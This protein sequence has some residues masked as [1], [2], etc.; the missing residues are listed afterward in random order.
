[1]LSVP[2][3]QEHAVGEHAVGPADLDEIERL[4]IELGHRL[5]VFGGDRDVA[6][7]GHDLSSVSDGAI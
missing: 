3:R 2:S 7:L 5:R 1:M 4:L 6:Q